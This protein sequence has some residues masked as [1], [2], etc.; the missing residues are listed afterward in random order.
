MK[1]YDALRSTND[2]KKCSYRM[3]R[4][5]HK[6]GHKSSLKT[7]PRMNNEYYIVL[8]LEHM[9]TAIE[10]LYSGSIEG[11]EVVESL[12]DLIILLKS[13][14]ATR[15]R[16]SRSILVSC[17]KKHTKVFNWLKVNKI[18]IKADYNIFSLWTE[19]CLMAYVS[20]F[21]NRI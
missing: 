16:M 11:K 6:I 7:C 10:S 12:C 15:E 3:L 13:T 2:L 19:K 18:K 14:M 9:A 8:Y 21:G 4:T 5:L 1:L 20:Q 17:L